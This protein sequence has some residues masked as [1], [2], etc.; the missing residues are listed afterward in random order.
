M[1][2]PTSRIHSP[3]SI[4][5]RL[6]RLQQEP[7]YE[8]YIQQ[9]IRQVL[10]TGQGERINRPDFGAGVRRLIFAPNS[11]ATASLAQTLIYQALTTWLGTLIRTEDVRAEADN[12]RLN[13]AI[14]YTILARQEQRFLNLEVTL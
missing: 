10:F 11:P 7:D 4:D 13:I 12:E 6:G 3:I 9:L 1:T 14:T 8:A 5:D 2:T